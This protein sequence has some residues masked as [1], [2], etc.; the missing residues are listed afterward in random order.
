MK[1]LHNSLKSK[2]NLRNKHR[3]QSLRGFTIVELLIVIVVIGI[4]AAITIV[5]YTGV[6]RRAVEATLSADLTSASQ[7]L[8]MYQVTYGSFPTAL[9]ANYCPTAPNI[10]DSYCLK[11]SP[12]NSYTNY[13]SDNSVLPKLFSIDITNDNGISY[14]I[15]E[16]SPPI[17]TAQFRTSCLDILN[18]SESTGDGDY[19][20]KPNNLIIS[21]YCDMSSDGGGWTRIS[22]EDNAS[23]VGWSDDNITTATISGTSTLV[24][25]IYDAFEGTE[26]TYDLQSIAHT[27][28]RIQGRY[29]AIDSWDNEV[30]GAQVWVDGAMVWSQIHRY[31]IATDPATGWTDVTFLPSL[32]SG[33]S[34]D[35]YWEIQDTLGLINHSSNSLL[36]GF[37]T[38]IN[39]DMTDESY[40]FSHVGVW[41]R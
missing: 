4:L 39:Q 28:A 9:D 29:Y 21:V 32:W 16:N 25:G 35:G 20:I 26:K 15:N 33:T 34:L 2:K 8:K 24:H 13:A 6:Q 11:I 19:Y 27:Q 22:Y 12:S 40:A 18:S 36:L 10:D 14:S 37:D 17:D 30:D 7:Q 31:N 23:S 3:T 1:A 5:S 38:N 41:I